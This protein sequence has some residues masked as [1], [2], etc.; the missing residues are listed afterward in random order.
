M[1]KSRYTGKA[2][3]IL[4]FHPLE[5]VSRYRDPQLSEWIFF[6][7]DKMEVGYFQIFLC[8]LSFEAWNCVGNLEMN[9]E[10]KQTIYQDEDYLYPPWEIK[11][12]VSI[13]KILYNIWKLTTY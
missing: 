9:K 11:I 3:I 10:S 8:I 5:I 2:L 7:F 6:R 13:D 4:N 12:N 1:L